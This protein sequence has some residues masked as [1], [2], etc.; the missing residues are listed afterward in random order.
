MSKTIYQGNVRL[1]LVILIAGL[2]LMGIKFV[3]WLLT[4]SNAILTD[5]LE[6]ILNVVAGGFGLFSL[7]LSAKPRD[8]NHPYGH[9]KI[10]FISAGFEGGLIFL[11]GFLIIAKAGYNLL[12][13][14]SLDKLDIGIILVA[15]SGAVN[16]LMG[17][18]LVRR[19]VQ[20]GSL[21]LQA[22]GKHLKSDAYSSAGLLTGLFVIFATGILWLDNL[23]A[24]LFGLIILYTG[25]KLLRTSVAGIMD[26]ADYQLIGQ[27]IEALREERHPNWI[28]VHNFRV[29]KYGATLHIDCHL[30]V[31][32]YFE[33]SE[34]H[35]EIKAFERSVAA[36][37]EVPVELFIHTDPCEPPNACRIC[38]KEDCQVREARFERSVRWSLKNFMKNKPHFPRSDKNQ[39][40]E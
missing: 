37:C 10:E 32:Y 12:Y 23:L 24:I 21:I 20:S 38:R 31:P 13:P 1:Q 6:S 25:Y 40:K 29:I 30:T 35:R 33:V 11:A 19:G 26:E 16:Y 18:L 9:G 22:S 17:F 36:H 2:M 27:I 34:A 14:Q 28:D 7:Y 39:L 5:A 4:N 3:A 15:F 8:M